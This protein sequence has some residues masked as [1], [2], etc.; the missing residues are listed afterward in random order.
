MTV[1]SHS[2]EEIEKIH[3]NLLVVDGHCDVI[4]KI[5][6]GK[7]TLLK[8][9]EDMQVDI[10]K[11]KRGNVGIQVFALF[12]ESRHK[13][14]N[15]LGRTIHLI[16]CFYSELESCKSQVSLGT[17][18]KKIKADLEAG[19]IISILGIE[20]GEALNGDAA[21]LRVLY[22]LGV[23]LLGLTWNQRNQLADGVSEGRTDGGLTSFG[24]QVIREMNRL[25]MIIDL[26]HI[27]EAG[28]W[29]V[30]KLSKDPVFVSHANCKKLCSH[31][32]NLSDDQIIALSKQ[33]GVLGLSFNPDFLV[34]SGK[35]TIDD[36]IDHLDHVA[37]LVGTKNVG[38]GSDFDGID[39]LPAGL[40]DSS[41]YPAITIKLIE[42][43]YT[44]SEIADIMGLNVLN[45]MGKIL[46]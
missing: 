11:L 43:G 44:E 31:P 21:V 29:D 12:I 40:E 6:D 15:A 42:R 45:L 10:N 26:S 39:S 24:V 25:G 46:K 36:F 41:C 22:R 28:F 34:S 4:L 17:S 9:T 20:G 8:G 32:R 7:G 5:A 37:S 16:D 19:K 33:G 35:A 18:I 30:L 23:R 13:P 27:S 1:W 38:I 3:S 14:F 2:Q